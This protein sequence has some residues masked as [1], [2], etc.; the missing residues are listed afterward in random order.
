MTSNEAIIKV[1]DEINHT[2]ERTWTL[3]ERLAGG[4]QSGAYQIRDLASN[5]LAVLKVAQRP[6]WARQVMRAAPIVESARAAGWPTPAWLAVGTT[7]QGWPY[8]IQEWL[9][10]AP[11]DRLGLPEVEMILEVLEIQAGIGPDGPQD[12]S[13][14]NYDVVFADR[15]GIARRLRDSSPEGAK[16]VARFCTLCEPYRDTTLPTGDLVHGDLSTHNIL[17]RDG[18]IVGIVDVEAVGRGPRVSDLACVLREGY[19]GQGDQ[20]ALD[21]LLGAGLAMTGVGPLLICLA[22]SVF[23][24]S[25]FVLDNSPSE[26]SRAAA[27]A[28]RL[29][30]VL[31]GV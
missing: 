25:G 13:A 18:G 5:Q 15:Y 28:L 21:N 20:A 4:H 7:T 9:D 6:E 29:A 31:G 26:W 22:A 12:W 23:A 17:V 16:I 19:M 2:H 14:Y 1:I 24:V 11:M 3:E 30:R 8:E 27:G 10:G